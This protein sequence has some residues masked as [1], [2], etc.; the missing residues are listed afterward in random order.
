MSS[1]PRPARL[2]AIRMLLGADGIWTLKTAYESPSA[3]HIQM[4]TTIRVESDDDVL[5]SVATILTATPGDPND[6]SKVPPA[7]PPIEGTS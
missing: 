3:H 5:Q 2:T 4:H 7:G 1:Q 6:Q